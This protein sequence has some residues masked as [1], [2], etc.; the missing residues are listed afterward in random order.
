MKQSKEI[1][2]TEIV[3]VEILCGHSINLHSKL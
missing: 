2:V 1:G 3:L